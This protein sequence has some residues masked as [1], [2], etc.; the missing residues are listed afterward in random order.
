MIYHVVPL[1]DWNEQA[2]ALHYAPPTFEKESFIH[3]CTKAQL[4]GVLERYYLGQFDLLLL[5]LDESK[6]QHPLKYE[7]ATNDELFP[8]LY[9]RINKEAVILIEKIS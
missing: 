7:K 2:S 8:H 6:L 3:C 4:A 5:H 1:N 9:G